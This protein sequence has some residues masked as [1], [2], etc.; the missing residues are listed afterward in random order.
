MR[1]QKLPHFILLRPAFFPIRN[2]SVNELVSV[3]EW[4]KINEIT[5]QKVGWK[6]AQMLRSVQF[7][8]RMTLLISENKIVME[9]VV[10]ELNN[11]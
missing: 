6:F 9:E 1:C 5:G 11:V 10:N 2:Y 8:L 4:N 7:Y 3:Y